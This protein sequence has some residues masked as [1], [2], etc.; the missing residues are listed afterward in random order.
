MSPS[1]ITRLNPASR[2]MRYT[3]TAV[4]ITFSLMVL[5]PTIAAAQAVNVK[6]S[7]SM[8]DADARMSS[9]LEQIERHLD[10]LEVK[11]QKSRNADSERKELRQ[12][13]KILNSQDL[14]IR[15]SFK[16]T[17]QFIHEQQL[18]QIM[19]ERHRA[20]IEAYGQELNALIDELEGIETIEDDIS[21]LNHAQRARDRLKVQKHK[22][23]QLPLDPDKLPF[24][25]A[26]SNTRSPKEARE[27]LEH[28][29]A[30]NSPVQVA[31][32]ELS[33][34]MLASVSTA[35]LAPVAA[36]LTESD[37]IQMTDDIKALAAQLKYQPVAIYNWVRNNT[38]YI[39][40]YGSVQNSQ[41][42]LT[43][44]RGNAFDTA[45]LLIALLRASNIPSRYAYGTVQIPIDQVMNWVGGVESPMAAL[46][47]LGQGGIPAIGVR[48]G[49]VIKFVKME[50]IWVEAWVD[51]HPSRGA[52]HRIGDS[53]VA[54]DAS[55]KQHEFSQGMDIKN[56]VSFDF[57]LLDSVMDA[58]Q[59]NETEGSV[60][61]IDQNR[62]KTIVE[63]YQT[64]IHSYIEGV[65]PEA[66]VGDVIGKR[67]IQSQDNP[68]LASGLPYQV[69]Q[70]AGNFAML[71][72][73][74]KHR[75][76]FALYES[77]VDQ[78][79]NQPVF[80]Y[81][82]SLARLGNQRISFAYE[83]STDADKSVIESAFE[84][85]QI[86]FPAYLVKMTPVIKLEDLAVAGGGSYTVGTDQIFAVEIQTPWYSRQVNYQVSSG[87]L[88][89]LGVNAAGL[90]PMAFD[91]RM[92]N[93]D[94]K[95][96]DRADY[97]LEMYHQIM[98]GYWGELNAFEDIIANV[99]GIRSHPL[100]GHGFA[101]SPV[102]ITYNFGIPRWATY[103]TRMLDV[104]E[105][106]LAAVHV[107]NDNAKKIDYLQKTGLV[108]SYLESGIYDQAFLMAPGHSMSAVTALAK[109]SEQG[110]PIYHIGD[111]N[112]LAAL[113]KLTVDAA[114]KADIANAVNAG[115]EV[116][117]S[118]DPV[119]VA[120]FNGAGYIITDPVTGSG[121]YRISG[122]REGNNSPAPQMVYPLPQV[123][124]TPVFGLMMR[125][126]IRTAG[127]SLVTEGG[128]IIGIVI[129]PEAVTITLLVSLL[130][131][132]M[133]AQN[134]VQQTIDRVY[135]E[136]D[137][138]K[139]Y[140]YYTDRTNIPFILNGFLGR[141]GLIFVTDSSGDHGEG[142]Y[143]A[144]PRQNRFKT[145]PRFRDNI[146]PLG[147]NPGVFC[148][149]S[150]A[151]P[152]EPPENGQRGEIARL[153]NIPRSGQVGDGSTITGYIELVLERERFYE[154]K[155]EINGN[156][157][158]EYIF[159]SPFFPAIKPASKKVMIVDGFNLYIDR[160][161]SCY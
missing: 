106:R 31:T 119:Q 24:K 47:L 159:R 105:N 125:S 158:R 149:P 88:W 39:P 29:F 103:K 124:A 114:I 75:I 25:A 28:I 46:D 79:K 49:G 9:T 93:H 144:D 56:Q 139:R 146:N 69:I 157:A 44:R 50:H 98:L 148:P 92:Q 131:A 160:E 102:D 134:V 2:F 55:F 130:I 112:M 40:T 95:Q 30:Q 94:L 83:P 6:P 110:I 26:D 121:S 137:V 107:Q 143:T 97:T 86:Q 33:A 4:L 99:A 155:E 133:I 42:T 62:I 81:S 41:S 96:T 18:P 136:L 128:V 27:E 132:L 17:E 65:K 113:P 135:P 5:Q 7:A 118:R 140:R 80:D 58:A 10:K 70:S 59:T 57:S 11:L 100:P 14:Q 85:Y 13:V 60:S 35:S 12:L 67:I 61:G 72:D 77:G 84:N 152:G 120:D 63:T 73:S 45:N 74:L 38:D 91:K 1:S 37:E 115:L 19:L 104:K 43:N 15:A 89:V 156:S 48:Q 66:T 68:F 32:L 123:P 109:A 51:Y 129:A 71:A 76:K 16:E 122:G 126:A 3:A 111:D 141:F 116:T 145:D 127:V 90:T 161:I 82:A 52:K 154:I 87:D 138:P 8:F 150:S 53:W 153:Y 22:R 64:Q 151:P 21:R 54:M 142:V 147:V 36:D 108:G 23:S 117:V 34:G 20:M 78:P 101:G